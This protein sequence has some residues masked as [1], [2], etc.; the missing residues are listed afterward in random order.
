M[1]LISIPSAEEVHLRLSKVY[2]KMERHNIEG[3]LVS[4]NANLYYLTG[5]V[6][7]GYIY[8]HTTHKPVYFVIRPVGLEGDNVV[9]IR[10][11]EQIPDILAGMGIEIPE[12]PGL[13]ETT[14][15][16]ADIM[17]MRKALNRAET[18][19]LSAAMSEARMVKTPYEVDLMREDGKRQALTY[20]MI[21][22]LYRD[23]MSDIELQIEIERRLRLNGCLGFY[24]VSGQL[25]ET[26]LG[27]ILSGDNAD[28]PTPYDFA[29]GGGGTDPSLPCGAAGRPIEAG[30]TVSVDACGN[31]NG[32]QTDMTRVWAHSPS[33][34]PE[35][36]LK[37]HRT[38]IQIHQ[39]LQQIAQPGVE[40]SSLYEEALRLV[41]EAGLEEYY[42]GHTQKASFIGHG[43][44]IELNEQPVITPRSRQILQAGMTIAIEPKFVI[45][46][47]GPAGIE[48]TYLVTDN[49]LQCLT[50]MQEDIMKL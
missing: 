38:S 29:V 41:R 16:Y 2:K 19:N 26:N 36:V 17:R 43:V 44:G 15:T 14:S 33:E 32:Y 3:A 45:P 11:P 37:A 28:N 6:F 13:E 18:H 30:S 31:F 1:K 24:R 35:T 50:P 7:R 10:K 34:L 27:T 4:C 23:G 42:M 9:Y 39:C 22:S 40:C 47:I 5:R 46:G 49:G 12:H 8:L 20:S 21:S 48:N 25:M